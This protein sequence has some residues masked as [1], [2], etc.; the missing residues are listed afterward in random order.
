MARSKTKAVVL[1]ANEIEHAPTARGEADWPAVFV[2]TR[3]SL[4]QS[5]RVAVGVGVPCTP[6]HDD[7]KPPR[8]AMQLDSKP[9]GHGGPMVWKRLGGARRYRYSIRNDTIQPAAAKTACHQG[10]PD[11]PLGCNR[12]WSRSPPACS[13]TPFLWIGC[14]VEQADHMHGA[15]SHAKQH[16][17]R[18][19]R[20]SREPVV[21]VVKSAREH[22]RAG[23][24]VVETTINRRTKTLPQAS[25]STLV[26]VDRSRNVVSNQ[27]VKSKPPSH[28]GGRRDSRVPLGSVPS[29]GRH[30]VPPR[31]GLLRP[32]ATPATGT[33]PPIGRCHPR[34][35]QP[36]GV[37]PQW[38]DSEDVLVPDAFVHLTGSWCFAQLAVAG[39]PPSSSA[40]SH[41]P[42]STNHP[43]RS[44]RRWL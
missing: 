22:L 18:E 44:T 15:W 31:A 7:R 9:S 19:L 42:V 26:P 4:L 32:D 13:P 36:R 39:T 5:K 17:V 43:S 6:G 20:Y 37:F 30:R 16:Q 27:E 24:D 2:P 38:E 21:R 28:P 12:L 33:I 23:D 35:P 34:A 3:T 14:R 1:E 25:G 41:K 10:R 40:A 29:T 8:R 11:P